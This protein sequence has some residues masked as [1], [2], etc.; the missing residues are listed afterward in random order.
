MIDSHVNKHKSQPFIEEIK[1]FG[2][3]DKFSSASAGLETYLLAKKRRLKNH[4]LTMN[5]S[6]TNIGYDESRRADYSWSYQ[7]YAYLV[8]RERT[9]Y[10]HRLTFSKDNKIIF[11]QINDEVSLM[12]DVVDVATSSNLPDDAYCCPNCGSVTSTAVLASE[13]CPSCGAHFK[14]PEL[15]PKVSHYSYVERRA[16]SNNYKKLTR[17]VALIIGSI[18]FIIALIIFININQNWFV[19]SKGEYIAVCITYWVMALVLGGIATLIPTGI[20]MNVYGTANHFKEFSYYRSSSKAER[21]SKDTSPKFEAAMKQLS[22]V[23]NYE[24]FCSSIYNSLG[25]ILFAEQESECSFYVGPAFV[26]MYSN[27]VEYNPLA[28]NI[29]GFQV[30]PD[31]KFVTV[32]CEVYADIYMY[33]GSGIERKKKLIRFPATRNLK[34]PLSYRF[35]AHAY[36]CDGCGSNFDIK[37]DS[38]CP[39]CGRPQHINDFD[40]CINGPI[41]FGDSK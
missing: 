36:K 16:D 26:G 5:Q 15:Y 33:N 17:K 23:F 3:L 12:T 11:D 35:A 27:I 7:D 21:I 10:K 32:H 9:E 13:G 24:F 25:S 2:I 41:A 31:R 28:L 14:M 8:T 38:C 30:S 37:K 1:Q 22:P 40:W 29:I 34:Y 4:G 18:A 19:Q 6:F 39:Y 20:I